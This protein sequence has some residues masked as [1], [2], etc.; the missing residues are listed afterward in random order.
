LLPLALLCP[1]VGG[2]FVSLR[3]RLSLA[4]VFTLWI[5]SLHAA[6][7]RREPSGPSDW[8]VG[9]GYELLLGLGLALGV[10]VLMVGLQLASSLVGQLSG[11]S[12]NDLGD[13][14]AAWG[15]TAIDRF[16]GLLTLATLLA[17]DGHRR[18]IAALLAGFEVVPPG[19]R[20]PNVDVAPLLAE[21]L[22]RSFQLGL[23]AAAPIGLALLLATVVMGL[24]ARA[25]PQLNAI[26]L[27]LSINLALLLAMS[28]LSLGALSWLFE[29]HI[30]DGLQLLTRA[31]GGPLGRGP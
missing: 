15:A 31:L 7:A 5:T 28:C 27:G 16:F 22:T 29:Q 13:P 20:P 1:G 18:V 30:V 2:R 26:G 25:I 3:V 11:L 8:A 19:A 12:L 23:R 4:L 17:V 14:A 9:L 6:S 10:L 21:L 24:L